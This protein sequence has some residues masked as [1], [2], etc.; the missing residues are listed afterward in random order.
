MNEIHF[1]IS[2]ICK[3]LN[4]KNW[5]ERGE[6]W[7][8]IANL[9]QLLYSITTLII[10]Y[11]IF[12]IISIII[13]PSIIIIQHFLSPSPYF[14]II[15]C[16]IYLHTYWKQTKNIFINNFYASN[17]SLSFFVAYKLQFIMQKLLLLFLFFCDFIKTRWK[18]H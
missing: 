18:F 4:G 2:S 5:N 10:S 9:I 14:F 6:W 7:R 16:I 8:W 11:L 12:I 3:N 17:N 15:F 13:I 1:L